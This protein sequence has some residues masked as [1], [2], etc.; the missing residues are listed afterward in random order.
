VA[1][2]CLKHSVFGDF[3][4]VGVAEAESLMG[5]DASGRVSR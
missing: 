5:G 4:L 3:N 2:S 1:A